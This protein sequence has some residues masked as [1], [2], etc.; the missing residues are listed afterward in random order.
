MLLT[1]SLTPFSE[2]KRATNCAFTRFHTHCWPW[3]QQPYSRPFCE[4]CKGVW[5]YMLQMHK[6]HDQGSG[7]THPISHSKKVSP[8]IICLTWSQEEASKKTKKKIW[9]ECL[10]LSAK[11]GKFFEQQWWVGKNVS[12]CL[13]QN[14]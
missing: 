12:H 13:K 3:D 5:G 1:Y 7:N 4:F 2:H 6:V 11:L 10:N 9:K 14:E 8:D